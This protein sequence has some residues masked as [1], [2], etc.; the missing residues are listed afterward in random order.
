VVWTAFKRLQ[1]ESGGFDDF[2]IDL[3]STRSKFEVESRI[4]RGRVVDNRQQTASVCDQAKQ[5][6]EAS[7]T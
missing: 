3:N 1:E 5:Q 6:M 7:E 4:S 2:R